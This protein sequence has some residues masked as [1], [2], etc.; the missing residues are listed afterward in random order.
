MIC[1]DWISSHGPKY[2]VF[3]LW[4]FIIVVAVDT[5]IC[6][7]LTM[8][9]QRQLQGISSSISL[10][11]EDQTQ[12]FKYL[13]PVVLPTANLTGIHLSFWHLFFL[14]IYRLVHTWI[15]DSM[16]RHCSFQTKTCNS[17]SNLQ[18]SQSLTPRVCD[19]IQRH[20]LL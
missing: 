20:Q 3:L 8:E 13:Q 5:L 4:L 17:H 9:V 10:S 16:Q 18:T 15:H 6:Y 19:F 11:P 2:R 14:F 12:V 7:S 1:W